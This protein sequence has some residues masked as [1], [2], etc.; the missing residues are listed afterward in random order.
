[1]KKNYRLKI[2]GGDWRSRIF[3]FPDI[4]EI[5]P[6]PSRM[7]ETLFNWLQFDINKSKCLDLYAGSGALGLE[8]LSRGAETVTF[9]DTNRKACSS[10]K[11][12]LKE[13]NCN[14][15]KVL[16]MPAADFLK[17]NKITFDIIFLD[18]PFN[19]ELLNQSLRSLRKN[20]ACNTD[21]LIFFETE[22][23]LEELTDIKIIKKSNSGESHIYLGKLN[24]KT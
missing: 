3:N 5:R 20:I 2:I 15:A 11:S 16:S 18:P 7:R 21:T 12:H 22:Q 13:L 23:V 9:V 24:I 10:I 6:T 8:A 4:K 17:R 1:M 14:T 19:S